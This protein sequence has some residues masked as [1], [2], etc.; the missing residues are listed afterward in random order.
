MKVYTKPV[1]VKV[2]QWNKPGDHPKV[3]Q[4][5]AD[6]SYTIFGCFEYGCRTSTVTPGCYIVENGRNIEVCTKEQLNDKY[7]VVEE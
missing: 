5:D 6:G 7:N 2:T 3:E 1:E 4:I